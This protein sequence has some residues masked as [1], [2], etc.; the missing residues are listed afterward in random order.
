MLYIRSNV[1]C[2]YRWCQE[3]GLARWSWWCAGTDQVFITIGLLFILTGGGKTIIFHRFFFWDRIRVFS[4]SLSDLGLK[5]L[6][7]IFINRNIGIL[8]RCHWISITGLYGGGVGKGKLH[9]KRNNSLWIGLWWIDVK[10]SR[11]GRDLGKSTT[12]SSRGRREPDKLLGEATSW[13]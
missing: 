6:K 10:I 2:C 9:K 11:L 3:S 12:E 1:F 7:G 13:R 4:T 5:E 8:Y